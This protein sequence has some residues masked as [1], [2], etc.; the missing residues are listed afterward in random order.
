MKLLNE[1]KFQ[2][3]TLFQITAAELRWIDA[4]SGPTS[5]ISFAQAAALTWSIS[6]FSFLGRGTLLKSVWVCPTLGVAAGSNA[7]LKYYPFQTFKL[8]SFIKVPGPV[9]YSL[10]LSP[11]PLRPCFYCCVHSWPCLLKFLHHFHHL[12]LHSTIPL[13]LSSPLSLP[14]RLHLYSTHY[15]FSTFSVF[16]VLPS[17]LRRTL[18]PVDW[19]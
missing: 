4:T 11:L 1:N 16:P 19:T 15:H 9:L 10:Q 8:D 14:L 2:C 13:P 18:F 7:G 6:C 17:V 12:I 3:E 5:K